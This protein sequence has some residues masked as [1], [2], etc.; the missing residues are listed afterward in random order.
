MDP[1][2]DQADPELGLSRPSLHSSYQFLIVHQERDLIA[3]GQC[4][5]F[6]DLVDQ[7]LLVVPAPHNP[8][9]L[10]TLPS[11]RKSRMVFEFSLFSI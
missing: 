5:Q 8:C 1:D 11:M 10:A 7:Q 9:M 3:S 4:I 6:Q 2:L